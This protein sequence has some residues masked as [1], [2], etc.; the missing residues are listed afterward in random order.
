[1]TKRSIGPIRKGA[2]HR[3][4]GIAPGKTIPVSTLKAAKARAKRTGNTKLLKRA[5]FALN[6]R[7]KKK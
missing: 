3:Q 1:M 2:L 7:G 4:L 5:T 6:F